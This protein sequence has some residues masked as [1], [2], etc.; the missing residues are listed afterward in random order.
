MVLLVL[1]G[2]TSNWA[3][4][5]PPSEYQVKAAFIYN[6][7]KF[8]DWPA[9]AFTDEKSPFAL[10]VYGKDPF[11]STLDDTTRGKTI[12][13]REFVV[14]RTRKIQDLSGCQIVFVSDS[15]S[16]H[17]PEILAGLHGT[18]ALLIGESPHFAEQGG[19]IQFVPE[20]KRIRFSINV[21]SVNRAHIRMSSK[22]LAL[23]QIV[24][25]TK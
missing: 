24:H 17:L 5:S 6:F 12:G 11:G 16:E 9:D 1:P 14:R 4:A 20:G 3:Q 10:C 15:E 8:V 23:A 19:Q 2:A 18:S 22:L 25:D 7:A 13:T 21:D